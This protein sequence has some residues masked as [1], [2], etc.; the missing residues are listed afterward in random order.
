MM[1][2]VWKDSFRQYCMLTIELVSKGPKGPEEEE[3]NWDWRYKLSCDGTL[4]HENV[5]TGQYD[6][7]P[8]L[9]HCLSDYQAM[10]TVCLLHSGGAKV[11]EERLCQWCELKPTENKFCSEH[12]EIEYKVE[13]EKQL[14]SHDAHMRRMRHSGT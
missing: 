9:R 10:V 7:M 8:S 1:R 4:K 3:N 12:C 13:I 11:E 5:I 2:L 14:K 6:I